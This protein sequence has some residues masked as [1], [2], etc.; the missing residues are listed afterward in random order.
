MKNKTG[1]NLNDVFFAPRRQSKE[2]KTFMGRSASVSLRSRRA[3][4]PFFCVSPA[5]GLQLRR[6]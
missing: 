6:N 5:W 3:G 1:E 4:L 2:H